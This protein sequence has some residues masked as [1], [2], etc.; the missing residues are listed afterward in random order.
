MF[1]NRSLGDAFRFVSGNTLIISV[2]GMLGNFA[3]A[4]VFPYLSLYILALGGN[5]TQIGLINSLKPLAGLIAF[6]IAGYIAD[7]ASRVKLIVL[8]NFLS[9]LLVLDVS[10]GS[11]LAVAG[12]WVSAAGFCRHHVSGALG[13]HRRL[14]VAG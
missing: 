14:L 8:A 4:M 1:R 12:S 13:P 10:L 6:P 11:H 9:A 7:H 3:R 5:A 2:T